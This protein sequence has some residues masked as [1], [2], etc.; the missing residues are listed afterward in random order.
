MSIGHCLISQLQVGNKMTKLIY[1]KP[2]FHFCTAFL[3]GLEM[4]P[5]L[6]IRQFTEFFESPFSGVVFV[7]SNRILTL[8]W[9]FH[10]WLSAGGILM[11]YI[12]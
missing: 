5:S 2:V 11:I 12:E 10:Y 8:F 4:E 3:G 7:T 6:K 1:F 9:C